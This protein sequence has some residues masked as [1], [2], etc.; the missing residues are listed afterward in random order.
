MHHKGTGK[1]SFTPPYYEVGALLKTYGVFGAMLLHTPLLPIAALKKASVLF[2]PLTATQ[3][4]PYFI[5]SLH[6]LSK[7]TAH[8]YFEDVSTR[9]A[10]KKL[11]GARCYL[12]AASKAQLPDE[13]PLHYIGYSVIYK[14]KKIGIIHQLLPSP[15]HPLAQVWIQGKAVLLPLS[16]E[17]ILHIERK[18][19]EITLLI[20]EGLLDLYL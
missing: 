17:H 14:G 4:L 20:P 1:I 11:T 9:E 18:Q 2:L 12:D 19:K 8:I 5:Q 15:A 10:A 13:T 6:I 16:S 3:Y 7:H